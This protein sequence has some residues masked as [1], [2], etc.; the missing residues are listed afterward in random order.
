[1]KFIHDIIYLIRVYASQQ[2]CFK[3]QAAG[4]LYLT[5]SPT[6]FLTEDGVPLYDCITTS[7]KSSYAFVCH[8]RNG[9]QKLQYSK[10][11][12]QGKETV[13]RK[14]VFAEMNDYCTGT[15]LTTL[16]TCMGPPKL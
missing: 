13:V 1:M 3:K 16:P 5:Y 11:K 8:G 2:D 15:T 6:S 12:C 10:A 4:V 7:K 9:I 14:T